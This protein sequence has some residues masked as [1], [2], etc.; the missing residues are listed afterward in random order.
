[1]Q[2]RRT[3]FANPPAKAG[4]RKAVRQKDTPPR[5]RRLGEWKAIFKIALPDFRFLGLR[6]IHTAQLGAGG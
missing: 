3:P 2:R 6:P 1:M 5:P 4:E